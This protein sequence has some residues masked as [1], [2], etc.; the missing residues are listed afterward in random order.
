MNNYECADGPGPNYGETAVF[1]F[2]RKVEKWPNKWAPVP[3]PN[4]V[5]TA[6]FAFCQKA[7][8]T[9]KKFIFAI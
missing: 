9:T 1:A 3:G 4:H 8:K 2:C 7:E 6:V 5:E